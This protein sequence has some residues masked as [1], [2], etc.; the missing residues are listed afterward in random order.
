M[1]NQ[2]FLNPYANFRCCAC[3]GL[4]HYANECTSRASGTRLNIRCYNCQGYGHIARACASPCLNNY[5]KPYRRCTSHKCRYC[6]KINRE[7]C[8]TSN[9][10]GERFPVRQM[11]DCQ[12]FSLIYCISCLRCGMQ[13]VGQTSNSLK[14][15]LKDHF[16]KIV[17]RPDH[18]ELSRHVNR[19]G[20]KLEDIKIHVLQLVHGRRRR[21]N[22]R[23]LEEWWIHQLKTKKPLGMNVY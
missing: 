8:I 6:P 23:R 14:Q 3:D 9:S 11:A 12:N 2:I 10:T 4:G 18:T 7:G 20:H 22:L 13:Y 19:H 17:H 5:R 1:P 16:H 15:R 21:L